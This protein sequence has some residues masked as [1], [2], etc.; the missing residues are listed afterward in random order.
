MASK[1]RDKPDLARLL[2]KAG[3]EMSSIFAAGVGRAACR[4]HV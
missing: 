4:A 1:Q 2:R 3:F